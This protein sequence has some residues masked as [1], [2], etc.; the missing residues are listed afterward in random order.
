MP[1]RF[2]GES[3]VLARFLVNYSKVHPYDVD[4]F[5]DLLRISLQPT[6]TDFSFVKI[7]LEEMVCK[8]LTNEQ[9]QHV[10]QRLFSLLSSEGTEETKVLS[11]QL[12]ILQRLFFKY[13][14]GSYDLI[15]KKQEN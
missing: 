5:F 9:K 8:V 1:P 11:I 4:V 7:F 13:T 6:A 15:N 3:K 2:H 12:M 14:L 10:M